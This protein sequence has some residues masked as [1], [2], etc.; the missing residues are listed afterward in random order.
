MSD[1][2][3]GRGIFYGV[4]GVATLVVAIIGATFAYFTATA[5]N[6]ATIKGNTAKVQLSLA[7]TKISNA[8]ETK[9]G[10]IPLANS[11]VE[12][13][14]YG[15][16]KE[17]PTEDVKKTV[18]TGSGADI[19]VDDNGNAVC[20]I[21]QIT[22]TNESTTG[23]FVDGYVSLKGGS[24]APNDYTYTTYGDSTGQKN[25]K[26]KINELGA[27]ADDATA[28][29][30]TMRWAQLINSGTSYSTA[31]DF[32]LGLTD[33]EKV[34]FTDIGVAT[35]TNGAKATNTDNI[36]DQ[37]TASTNAKGV[38]GNL[39]INGT[40]TYYVINKNYIRVSDHDWGDGTAAETYDRT[41]DVTSALVYNHY[42]KDGA[43][44]DYYIVVWLTENG[45]NQTAG[46]ENKTPAAAN[47]F[48]GNVTFVSSQGNEVSAT[49]QSYARVQSNNGPRQ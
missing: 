44:R 15:I 49:F 19:C 46:Q 43:T 13:A 25:N 8:D 34:T 9:G 42:L 38:Y 3:K 40:D 22:L 35:D 2:N 26:F 28:F 12:R 23:V 11:M 6:T 47:F 39:A 31:G 10:M 30:T 32:Q 16:H 14:V 45:Q 4:I 36:R 29:N 5:A 17:N 21:Y 48:A 24:G 27:P 41:A 33:T 20:Q 7:V 18:L 1:N 37:Y